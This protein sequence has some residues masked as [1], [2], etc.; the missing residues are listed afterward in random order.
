MIKI[1][2]FTRQKAV[3][4]SIAVDLCARGCL[5]LTLCEKPYF[6]DFMNKCQPRFDQISY[7]KVF[8]I[9]EE[10]QHLEKKI[11]QEIKIV[12]LH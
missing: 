8:K 9:I 11:L 12:A 10:I 3:E 6:R 7:R 5:P 1:S 4:R 2:V